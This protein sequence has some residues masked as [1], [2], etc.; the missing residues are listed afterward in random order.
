MA[1]NLSFKLSADN[2]P[3]ILAAQRT[4]RPDPTN[5][6]EYYRGGWNMSDEHYIASAS[7]DAIPFFGVAIAWILVMGLAFLIACCCRCCCRRHRNRSYSHACHSFSLTLVILL[8]I[9]TIIGCIILYNGQGNFHNSAA[10]M[11]GYLNDQSNFV[12]QNLKNISEEMAGSKKI[13]VGEVFL[14]ADLRTQIDEITMKLSTSTDKLASST[15]ETFKEV[16]NLLSKL[17]LYMSITA[18][19]MLVLAIFGFLF[20]IL[21]LQVLVYGL[22]FI[23]W[24]L[25]AVMLALSGIF[26][27]IHNVVGDTCVAMDEWVARPQAHTA[28]DDIFP[29]VDQ[30]TANETFSRSRAITFELVDMVNG[31]I[32]NGSNPPLNVNQS[33]PLVPLLCNP[34]EP[35]LRQRKCLSSEVSFDK[36][37]Q[38]W[39][40][41]ICNT[42][43][44]S[45][46]EICSSA[47]RITQST[48]GEMTSAASFGRGLYLHTPFIVKLE[49]CSFA[50]ETFSAI[51]TDYCPAFERST[52]EMFAGLVVVA[53]AVM[54]SVVLWM[55]HVRQRKLRDYSRN[56]I[57][58]ESPLIAGGRL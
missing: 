19:V 38:V 3:F 13:K 21:G 40:G 44:I 18:A 5:G 7:V 15:T 34:Y 42:K 47:G 8:T 16:D 4:L 39:K 46:N 17:R 11:L 32:V 45:G 10:N 23:G 24:I 30:A 27:F 26:L 41:F 55:V 36:A 48:Y 52:K 58:Q 51:G 22:V 1:D 37:P 50:R 33:G 12:V 29:C 14:P 6:Y 49:D 54:L 9:T 56:Y 53:V 25:V 28:L 20:S 2:S 43:V 57:T 31:F 35:D